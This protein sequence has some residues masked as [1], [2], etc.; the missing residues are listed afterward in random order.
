MFRCQDLA[1]RFPDLSAAENLTPRMKLQLKA[2]RRTA[3]YRISNV[4]VWNRC[5]Q[6]FLNKKNTLFD[7]GCW[8]FDAYSPPEEDSM[9]TSFS[10]DLTGRSRPAAPLV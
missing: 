2:N 8:T 3:E 10:L 6:S 1:P 4:E 9:F 5:A 7:V